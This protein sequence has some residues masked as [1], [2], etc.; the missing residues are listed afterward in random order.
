MKSKKPKL[1]LDPNSPEVIA[2]AV[3]HIRSMTPEEALTFLFYHTPGVEETDMRGILNEPI[4]DI[5]A[6][7]RKP[8]LVNR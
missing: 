3:E 7:Q 1:N 6:E 4:V 8:H 5:H 2:R